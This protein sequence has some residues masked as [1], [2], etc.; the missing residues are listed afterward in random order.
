MAAPR[1]KAAAR[2]AAGGSKP[3]AAQ[4]ERKGK[5]AT[6]D[7]QGLKIKVPSKLPGTLLFD[8]ADLEM[9]RDLRGT[10]EFV[11]SLLG[12]DQY[13]AVREKISELSMGLDE[14]MEALVELLEGVLDKGGLSLGES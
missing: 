1:K 4:R 2:K 14:T 11:K 7:F 5:E 3:A 13:R 12:E 8:I 9:G 10:M 6:V